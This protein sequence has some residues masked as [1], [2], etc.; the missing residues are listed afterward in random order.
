MLR[1]LHGLHVFGGTLCY[2]L[3][4]LR[5]LF[6][7]SPWMTA[8]K[9][10]LW[11]P[12][13]LA[14]EGLQPYPSPRISRPLVA[15]L[16]LGALVITIISLIVTPAI[17]FDPEAWIVWARELTGPLG[18]STYGG[19]SWHPG[20][21]FLMMP[22]TAITSG[23]ADVYYWLLLERFGAM[24][25]LVGAFVL[26]ARFAGWWAAI[27]APV[28]IVLSPWWL[29]YATVGTGVA[30]CVG[31]VMCSFWAIAEHR[32]RL[33]GVMLLLVGLIRPEIWPFMI[34]Y[35]AWLAYRRL[36]PVWLLVIAV[37]GTGITWFIPEILHSGVGAFTASMAAPLK[38]D[39]VHARFP[40][41]RVSEISLTQLGP[42]AVVLSA[43]GI[44]ASL[45]LWLPEGI[46]KFTRRL[47][48]GSLA[49]TDPIELLLIA[50]GLLW[51]IEV[52]MMTQV[53][54][55][56]GNARYLEPG[57]AALTVVAAITA[58]RL[59]RSLTLGVLRSPV[60]GIAGIASLAIAFT[61]VASNGYYS[62]NVF[63]INRR[64]A[65]VSDLQAAVAKLS[66]PAGVWSR[67]TRS[68]WL[69]EISGE[70]MQMATRPGKA[71]HGAN[72]NSVTCIVVSKP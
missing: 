33:A 12:G 21:V 2:P 28:L 29:F 59:G 58:V 50:F 8:W 37:A 67:H 17:T 4:C 49:A 24:S 46:R 13:A 38:S 26:G 1:E 42:V 27:L 55:F 32:Y 6:E 51:L 30:M 63:Q 3:R 22:F 52:A 43:I 70:T 47:L 56:P 36:V 23:H 66:C 35:G 11:P 10:R 9:A 69:A 45:T 44:I 7:A 72:K 19:P 5:S 41:I 71:P 16:F 68:P 40:F 62:S 64:T 25:G 20:P 57:L 48:P 65:I 14:R 15:S 39:G 31:L 53:F 18:F 60:L 34:L 61:I 54:H